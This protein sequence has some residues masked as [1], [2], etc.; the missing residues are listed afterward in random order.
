MKD[1]AI[2]R[3]LFSGA[4]SGFAG[5]VLLQPLDLLKTRI[6]RGDVVQQH[7]RG[8]HVSSVT[9]RSYSVLLAISSNEMA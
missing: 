5:A 7:T 2:G 3:H 6:R 8:T 9:P 4:L 1:A